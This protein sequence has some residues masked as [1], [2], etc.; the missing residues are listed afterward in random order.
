[1]RPG[2]FG[3]EVAFEAPASVIGCGHDPRSGRDEV[4]SCG[5]VGDSG[6]SRRWRAE[7]QAA[8]ELSTGMAACTE[9]PPPRGL[10]SRMV[11]PSAST[12]SFRPISPDPRR[13]SAPPTPSS[14]IKT[15]TMYL[16]VVLMER[17]SVGS[18][19]L[20]GFPLEMGCVIDAS[21]N[22]WLPLL[23]I[24][25]YLPADPGGCRQPAHTPL[26]DRAECASTL[27]QFRANRSALICLCSTYRCRDHT[28]TYKASSLRT[29]CTTSRRLMPT[30]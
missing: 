22:E 11:P 23:P 20:S 16:I 28:A 21:S 1:M 30:L 25:E 14:A 12:R 15:S 9:V 2:G 6:R 13:G 27:C 24:L 10:T 3:R 18:Q 5:G 17:L 8:L 4:C 29:P 19:P 7:A 26:R